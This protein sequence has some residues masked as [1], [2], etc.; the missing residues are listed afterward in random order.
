MKAQ[1]RARNNHRADD[2]D[3]DHNTVFLAQRI[4]NVGLDAVA[5]LPAARIEETAQQWLA[6]KTFDPRDPTSSV[7]VMEAFA[8]A[9]FLTLFSSSL[10]GVS[11]LERFV[12]QRRADADD[13]SRAALDVL[14]K[15]EFHLI[16][17]KARRSPDRLDVEDLATGE[18]LALFDRDIPATALSVRVAAWLAPLPDGGFVLLGPVTPLDASALAEGLSF[19]R[20]GKGLINARRCAAAV[21]R[22]VVRHGGLRVEGLNEFPEDALDDN[23]APRK[24]AMGWIGSPSL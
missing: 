24:S 20:P 1:P 23:G 6:K 15:T 7:R 14:A 19:V 10:L 8:L 22:H 9:S 21:Y 5:S 16:Q 17:M 12:R 3:V 18:T 13:L 2:R 11:P 4:Q